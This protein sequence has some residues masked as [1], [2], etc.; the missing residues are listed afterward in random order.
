MGMV[1]LMKK[2]KKRKAVCIGLIAVIAMGTSSLVQA[3]EQSDKSQVG[4]LYARSAVLIDADSGRILYGKNEQEVRPMASTT[5]IMTCIL[6]LENM[7][8]H[9]VAEASEIASGQPKVRLGMQ[10][11][12]KFY[13]KDLLYSLMLESHNDSAVA[14][15]EAVS[16]SVEAFAELMNQKAK[17]IGCEKTHFITPNGLDASDDGGVHATTAAE[18]A[19]IMKYCIT[20]SPKR[21]LFLQI[22]QTKQYAFSDIEGSAQYSCYN[23]NALLTMME[24]ALSGKTGFTADAGYCYVGA[25]RK[26]SRIFIVALL[27]CG[28]PNNKGYKWKDMKTLMTY[29]DEN[30]HYRKLGQPVE[31]PEIPVWNG[32]DMKNPYGN[33][34]TAGLAMKNAEPDKQILLG[35]NENVTV[36]TTWKEYLKAP[37]RKN[38]KVGKIEY[39]INGEIIEEYD[40]V[41]A[42]QVRK[43]TYSLCLRLVLLKFIQNYE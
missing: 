28:W 6:A 13:L 42:K 24:G 19:K 20:E 11:G 32:V 12:E 40:V 21:A 35:K 15:A 38:E 10:V 37:V 23:H 3:E 31:L 34:V 5:K 22:T 26:D 43:R 41:A 16:G 29:A 18:L 14:V 27:A 30:Y 9:Q 17:S 36:K 7:K 33:E 1:E 8:E 25:V 2:N 4:E 39:Q